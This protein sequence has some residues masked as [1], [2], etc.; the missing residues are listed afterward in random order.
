MEPHGTRDHC[1]TVV[2]HGIRGTL[3]KRRT[4]MEPRAKD[5]AVRPV[6]LRSHC[7]I[8]IGGIKIKIKQVRVK[9][10]EDALTR[11]ALMR[12]Y[13]CLTFAV[14]ARTGGQSKAT[15]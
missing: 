1:D 4:T 7:D 12:F 10:Q 3:L 11:R 13:E 14:S 2:P 5:E 9:I 8:E 15:R 6:E